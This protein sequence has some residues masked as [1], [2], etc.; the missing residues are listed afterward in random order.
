MMHFGPYQ[1]GSTQAEEGTDRSHR[2]ENLIDCVHCFQKGAKEDAKDP[3]LLPKSKIKEMRNV[4]QESEDE[5]RRFLV[6]MNRLEQRLPHIDDW[7]AYEES[8]WHKGE[9]PY[10]DAIEMMD[11]IP[12]EV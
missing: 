7:K 9:T 3:T 6:Q 8:L 4:L 1:V 2:I 12:G 5:A 10:V 11:F